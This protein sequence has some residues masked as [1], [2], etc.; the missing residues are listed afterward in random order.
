[1]YDNV[2]IVHMYYIVLTVHI[3]C[4]GRLGKIHGLRELAA[5]HIVILREPE[6][7]LA[8]LVQQHVVQRCMH[9]NLRAP[10]FGTAALSAALGSTW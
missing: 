1:M 8:E 5:C 3:V 6:G 4:K 9:C 7:L 2:L 10:H